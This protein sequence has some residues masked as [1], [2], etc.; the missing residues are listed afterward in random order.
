MKA[1]QRFAVGF[2]LLILAGTAYGQIN[3]IQNF[4]EGNINWGTYNI[5]CTGVGTY[6]VNLPPAQH[7]LSAINSARK[8]I[9]QKIF[10]V[11][12]D[13]NLNAEISVAKYFS[14]NPK[15]A[16]Q[17]Q[18]YLNEYKIIGKPRL[19]P[20]S[21]VELAVEYPLSGNA[22]DAVLPLSGAKFNQAAYDSASAENLTITGL[23]I[24]CRG[25]GLVYALAPRV[26][27]EASGEVFGLDWVL[28]DYAVKGGL[29]EYTTS[30]TDISGRV[31]PNP[32]TLLGAGAAGA[33]LCDV[34]I[35]V[36]DAARINALKEQALIL[37]QCRV[38]FLID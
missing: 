27:A 16:N 21:T 20:D 37:G 8:D 34:I 6:D 1:V 38:V 5:T 15:A 10:A 31:G 11:I 9:S 14:Q 33:N 23:V 12:K 26:L 17:L 28:R 29:V 22:L 35:S 25:L 18:G 19:M 36:G 3:L 4:P 7:R 24:D 13:L 30:E 2:C 32:I